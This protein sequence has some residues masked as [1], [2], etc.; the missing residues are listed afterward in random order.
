M[1]AYLPIRLCL[2]MHERI[3]QGF[4][5]LLCVSVCVCIINFTLNQHR[6]HPL[7]PNRWHAGHTFALNRTLSSVT[8]CFVMRERVEMSE[9][10]DLLRWGMGG[11][12][13]SLAGVLTRT[14]QRNGHHHIIDAGHSP[15]ALLT[16]ENNNFVCAGVVGR[17]RSVG[18]SGGVNFTSTCLGRGT[19][20]R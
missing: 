12:N 7:P 4:F 14:H 1:L 18:R 15:P 2:H 16:S 6:P 3:R 10:A 8:K 19:R 13:S 5:L 17:P 20:S 11:S 9:C